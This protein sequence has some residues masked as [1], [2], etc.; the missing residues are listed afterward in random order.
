MSGT[1]TER[2]IS[3]RRFSMAFDQAESR[4][5]QEFRDECDINN[6]MK[7]WK[8]GQAI[9]HLNEAR[10]SFGDFTHVRDYLTAFEAVSEAQDAFAQLSAEIRDRMGNDPATL[11]AFMEDPENKEEAEELGLLNPPEEP[12]VPEATSV[13]STPP[14]GDS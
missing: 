3:E 5:K 6:I 2:P 9:S 12:E 7:R 1:D 8:R 4:T 10:P 11:L 14:E 13:P